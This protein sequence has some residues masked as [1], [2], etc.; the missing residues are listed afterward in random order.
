M[1]AFGGHSATPFHLIAAL[2][3]VYIEFVSLSP[4]EARA[5]LIAHGKARGCTISGSVSGIHDQ[6]L[7]AP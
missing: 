3:V 1:R 6:I 2:S 5:L 4:R 7:G